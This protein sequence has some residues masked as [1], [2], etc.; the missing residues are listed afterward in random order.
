V[1]ARGFVRS[2]KLKSRDEWKAYYKA[3]KKPVDIPAVPP[4]IYKNDWKSWGD[5]LGSGNI[6]PS[7]RVFLSFSK[8]KQ[9]V[10]KLGLKN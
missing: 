2:L 7:D 10:S 4:H 9:F 5:W 6:A 1:K 3:G 8:S